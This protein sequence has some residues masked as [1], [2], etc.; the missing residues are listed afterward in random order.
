MEWTP[1]RPGG[2]ALELIGVLRTKSAK[3]RHSGACRSWSSPAMSRESRLPLIKQLQ[4]FLSNGAR[5]RCG[6]YEVCH[7]GGQNSVPPRGGRHFPVVLQ[8][9][10][11]ELVVVGLPAIASQLTAC[12]R[13]EPVCGA[14]VLQVVQCFT[15]AGGAIV[16]QFGECLAQ[17]FRAVAGDRERFQLVDAQ[18]GSRVVNLALEGRHE[19]R[20]LQQRQ[21]LRCFGSRV[22]EHIVKTRWRMSERAPGPPSAV[23]TPAPRRWRRDPPI[24]TRWTRR[25]SGGRSPPGP[26][27]AP[28]PRGACGRV[29]C[30][31]RRPGGPVSR[32]SGSLQ[33]SPGTPARFD[34]KASR[35]WQDSGRCRDSGALRR[36]SEARE[37]RI[38]ARRSAGGGARSAPRWPCDRSH[39]DP[40]CR[41]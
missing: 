1:P 26:R 4:R 7:R 9:G 6:P 14:A 5:R 30:V 25:V 3:L 28:R 11:R 8:S 36:A 38:R 18:I 13:N 17:R 22:P 29:H 31:Q 41:I 33:S 12:A 10:L 16:R 24:S 40:G 23:S 19:G 2:N 20:R 27:R 15:S 32:S 35:W 37:A 21:K 34:R 39:E